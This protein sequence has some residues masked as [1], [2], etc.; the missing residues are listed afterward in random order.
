M[1]VV[2]ELDQVR[3]VVKGVHEFDPGL[4]V[5]GDLDLAGAMIAA[6]NLDGVLRLTRG[7]LAP[8]LLVAARAAARG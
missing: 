7:R 3:R 8:D 5:G 6:G 4:S 2:S 1:L